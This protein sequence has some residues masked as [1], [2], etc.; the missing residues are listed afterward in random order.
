VCTN[1]ANLHA[2]AAHKYALGTYNFYATNFN[3]DSID[4][5]GMTII[6]TVQYCDPSFPCP[7]DNSFWDGTQMVYG[8]KYGDPLADDIVGHELT[9]GVTQY[10]SNLFYYYQ[11]GAINESL[12]DVFGEYYD[13][14]G[15]ATG[16][17]TAGVK[18][19]VG[20]DISGLGAIRSMSNPPAYGDPDKMSSPNYYT[21]NGD[22]GGVHFNSGVNNK[23]VY[24]MVDGG[25]FNSKTV[26]GLGWTKVGA[27]YYEAQTNLLT[28]A[29]DYSD[30]YYILQQ[31]CTN[32]IGQKGIVAGDCTQVKNALDA[33][34]MSRRPAL[35]NFDDPSF[36][37]SYTTYPYWDQYSYNFYTPLCTAADCGT[38]AGTAGLDQCGAGLAAQLLM[39]LGRFRKQCI[40]RRAFLRS[41][42][43]SISGLV[44]PMPEV[45]LMITS[46]PRW[47]A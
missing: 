34:E 19:L 36:E 28:S 39:R 47:M 12:S 41:N 42:C 24:L 30:L 1:G 22:N 4:N 46:L 20:E 2:D 23:A 33:V 27:I 15:N 18:W 6:S 17:D 37:Y 25:A 10:E 43:V 9:H 8:S 13:Q 21:G 32:L 3:R 45:V 16:G 38:N 7:F 26:T 40:C 44:E 29:S 5:N 35:G 11:S 14:V 31:A